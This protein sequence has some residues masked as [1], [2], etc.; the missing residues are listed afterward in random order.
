MSNKERLSRRQFLR[1]AAIATA[2]VAVVACQ[3]QTVIV[4]ETVEVEK[5][6]KETVQVE[7]EVEKEVTK[8]VE[9]EVTKVVEKMVEVTAVPEELKESPM[10]FGQVAA[11]TLPPLEERLPAE[12]MVCIRGHGFEQ[13][14][15]T[16][17]GVIQLLGTGMPPDR[18]YLLR[19]DRYCTSTEPHVAKGW[20]FSADGTSC[21]LF[22]RRGM[23]WSDGEPFTA[24]D[25]VYWWE[26]QQ[27]NEELNTAPAS[28]W[29]H[30]G[31]PMTVEKVDDYTLKYSFARP[32]WM[33]IH[34]L[35][36][37]GYR[38]S[39]FEAN[40]YDCMHYAQQ[41]H[42]D[43][44]AQ[45]E[46]NALA[47]GYDDWMSYYRYMAVNGTEPGTPVLTT[48][49][50]D[51]ETPTGDYG[52]RNAYYYKVDTE[53]NQLPYIDAYNRSLRGDP[54]TRVLQITAGQ[55]DFE[56]WGL[57]LTQFPVLKASEDA[58]G[59]DA[60]L[61]VD[62]WTAATQFAFNHCYD[63]DPEMGDLLRNAQFRRALSVAIDRDEIND[64]MFLGYGRPVQMTVTPDSKWY[65]EEWAQAYA[66]FDP[67]QAEAWLD[68][69]GLD[70]RDAEGF[71]TMP[72]GK[73]LSL[74]VDVANNVP[75]WIPTSE[76][77]KEQWEAVGVRTILNVIASDLLWERLSANQQHGWV[78][79]RDAMS[80]FIINGRPDQLWWFA[81]QWSNWWNS[82]D[83]PEPAGI[84]PPDDIKP[85]YEA[86]Q[87]WLH[88][89]EEQLI[90]A[91]TIVFDD[92]A[93]NIR[94]IGT[95]APGGQPCIT[96]RQ[97]GNVD[98]EAHADSYDTG[99]TQNCWLETFFWKA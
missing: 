49:T 13:E 78:W 39:Q 82:R 95:G 45:A 23:K 48:W 75:F 31:T 97:L 5:V 92:Q 10:S 69:I 53:G 15:G 68:E 90:E 62:L 6:V 34:Q 3:P 28:W 44:N 14:V 58:G 98:I 77:V 18:A 84:E 46:A 24:D 72:S 41:F 21:T 26:D 20:E 59:Y 67:D 17:G 33:F 25:I 94:C 65:K 60:W 79:V 76:I 11:G 2:G 89:D 12:P 7:V 37:T 73:Q 43:Y 64:V 81:Q 91:I 56:A 35:D 52:E 93:E 27:L 70:G 71:R 32:F 36:A 66:E 74:I 55:V 4:K 19:L 83:D 63:E 54:E 47:A 9:K 51:D 40:A 88:F 50:E 80:Q 61:G 38:G 22:L 16:Y 29:R 87:G 1:S 96:N 99:G 30:D 57:T 8:V 85:L 86:Q 42:P